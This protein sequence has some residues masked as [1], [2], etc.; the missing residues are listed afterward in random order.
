MKKTLLSAAI[1]LGAAAAGNASAGGIQIDPTGTGNIGSSTFLT[2]LGSS[3]GNFLADNS[4]AG[5]G[6]NTTAGATTIYAHNSI[7]ILGGEL[8]AV[9]TIPMTSS[10]DGPTTLSL[11]QFDAGTFQLWFGALN[12]DQISGLG[13]ADGTLIASGVVTVVP[14]LS[15]S[16]VGA[17]VGDLSPANGTAF[18]L[19]D[20]ITGNGSATITVDL[21]FQNNLFVVNNVLDA[22]NGIDVQVDNALRLNY[23]NLSG[24]RASET[25]GNGAVI[26]SFGSDAINNFACGGLEICDFE[27]QMNSTFLFSADRIPEP[28]TVALMG[29]GLG[30][31]GGLR[32]RRNK[33]QG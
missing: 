28:G 6:A 26:P 2:S 12:A 19:T 24:N 10:L 7:P 27:A 31:L 13:Y 17:G 20:S 1:V 4:L 15:F 32:A 22:A 23:T 16:R 3:L 25:F 33:K 29:L 18:G 14:P 21:D 8:T 5:G 11:E 30:L 9:F